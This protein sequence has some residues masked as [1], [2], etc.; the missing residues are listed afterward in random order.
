M[1]ALCVVALLCLLGLSNGFYYIRNSRNTPYARF[2]PSYVQTFAPRGDWLVTTNPNTEHIDIEANPWW[3]TNS[4]SAAYVVAIGDGVNGAN[5]NVK[6]GDIVMIN[7]PGAS[8]VPLALNSPIAENQPRDIVNNYCLV[9]AANII[10]TLNL[11]D[12]SAGQASPSR[13]NPSR[14]V[15]PQLNPTFNYVDTI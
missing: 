2:R 4:Y 12:G 3:N 14:T 1:R 9:T 5:V 15:Y 11:D 8:C 13:Y 6:E 10:G 7:A